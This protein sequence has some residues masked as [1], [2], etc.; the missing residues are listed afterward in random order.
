MPPKMFAADESEK[1]PIMFYKLYTQKRH[2]KM[3]EDDS[4]F[5]LAVNNNLK[6][7]SGASDERVVQGWSCWH[8]HT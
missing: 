8:K 2:E 3:N 1:Y 6:A 4:P 5:Y 7:K